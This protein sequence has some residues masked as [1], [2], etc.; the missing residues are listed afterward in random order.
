VAVSVVVALATLVACGAGTYGRP[1]AYLTAGSTEVEADRGT[2]CWSLAPGRSECLDAAGPRGGPGGTTLRVR[3]G[4]VVGLRFDR[5]DAPETL[6]ATLDPAS[7]GGEDLL[8]VTVERRNPT[9]FVV[10]VPPGTYDLMMG[11]VWPEGDAAFS[12]RIVVR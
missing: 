6:G 4:A 7:V 2:S 11:T 12:L 3:R 10:D 5:D 8:G 9:S 1:D